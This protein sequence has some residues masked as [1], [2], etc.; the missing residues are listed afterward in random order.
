M[1]TQQQKDNFVGI[2]ICIF[3]MLGLTI[4]YS[5]KMAG[6]VITVVIILSFILAIIVSIIAQRQLNLKMGA[7]KSNKE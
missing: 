1:K 3:I 7:G 5:W 6:I 4:F 2:G